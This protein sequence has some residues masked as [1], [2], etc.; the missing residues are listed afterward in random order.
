MRTKVFR[1][2]TLVFIGLDAL[3]MIGQSGDTMRDFHNTALTPE[4]RAHSLVSQMTLE[5]KVG[6][7][8][9]GAAAIPRLS[10]PAYNY[11]NEGL[12]GV[13]RAG[14]ATMFPQAIEM[15]ATWDDA[16]IE[17]V[18]DVISTEARAKNNEA[19]RNGN[20]DIYF[21]FTFWSPN[22][23]IFRDPRW[24]RGQETCGEDP[25]LTANSGEELY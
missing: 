18:G 25:F 10:I 16:L 1:A 4:A 20:H 23:N 5:E 12:H 15:A 17:R 24:G 19:L 21:G 2:F 6:Q 3:T 9:S 14:Y 8:G 13:A 22:I 7:M 11:W